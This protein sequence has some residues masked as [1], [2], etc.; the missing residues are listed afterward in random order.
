MDANTSVPVASRLAA[1][2]CPRSPTCRPPAGTIISFW[3]LLFTLIY[4]HCQPRQL[5]RRF[6]FPAN[7]GRQTNLAY[8]VWG[9][10]RG[11]T[12][13]SVIF[14]GGR[15]TR[16][17]AGL[18]CVDP[19]TGE[20]RWRIGENLCWSFVLTGNSVYIASNDDEAAE[21]LPH[22]EILFRRKELLAIDA[23]TGAV[24]WRVSPECF[25]PPVRAALRRRTGADRDLRSQ[26][27]VTTESAAARS[28]WNGIPW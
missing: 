23:R 10:Q 13:E 20:Q 16:D 8:G 9:S 15:Q 5:N 22:P 19:R 4:D 18:C 28:V 2:F 26:R 12:S 7:F 17:T 14:R 1:C 27:W 3:C 25:G 24:R 6:P 11:C 21:N